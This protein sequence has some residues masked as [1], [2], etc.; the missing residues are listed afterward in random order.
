MGRSPRS[1]TRFSGCSG[2]RG[3]SSSANTI[4]RGLAL[5][6]RGSGAGMR[7]AA[8]LWRPPAAGPERPAADPQA[9]GPRAP[10][11]EAGPA[12]TLLLRERGRL[13][14]HPRLRPERCRIVAPP[15]GYPRGPRPVLQA[16]RAQSRGGDPGRRRDD[17]SASRAA[18]SGVTVPEL[19][20]PPA[21]LRLSR[22][23]LVTRPGAA[24]GP[25]ARDAGTAVG[26]AGTGARPQGGAVR[27]GGACGERSTPG[28]SPPCVALFGLFISPVCWDSKVVSFLFVLFCFC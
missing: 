25:A 15:C 9:R 11:P 2:A 26:A 7:G 1:L 8:A 21:R 27:A 14:A 19:P 6:S 4:F 10:R 20:A 17:P 24:P 5:S 13:A 18:P 16:G 22:S 23:V 28:W 12:G 3:R